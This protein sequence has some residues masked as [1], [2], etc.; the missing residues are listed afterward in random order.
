MD[1]ENQ[2]QNQNQN[3]SNSQNQ[4]QLQG[5]S[6][7][8]K[9][10][11][12]DQENQATPL[13]KQLSQELEELKER[14]VKEETLRRQILED[15]EV[16]AVFAARKENKAIKIVSADEK[17]ESVP[18]KQQITEQ[19]NAGDVKVNELTN[20]ELLEILMPA[21]EGAIQAKADETRELAESGA[22]DRL[23]KIEQNQNILY[24]GLTEQLAA[25]Q[26]VRLSEKYIDFDQFKEETQR[27]RKENPTL[28]IEKCYLLAKAEAGSTIPAANEVGTERPDSS[29]RRTVPIGRDPGRRTDYGK[30]AD[31]TSSDQVFR[32]MVEA[33]TKKVLSRR[34][35]IN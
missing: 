4:R 17:Q 12:Q 34:R 27:V 10:N 3:Q 24:K 35:G 20:S 29:I 5:Q 31:R 8:D 19:V 30:N 6:Q 26:F 15:P 18:L 28:P 21:F 11:N 33:G 25:A 23:T 1:K 22:N 16:A 13:E 9:Q 2:N 14:Q 7:G 32:N